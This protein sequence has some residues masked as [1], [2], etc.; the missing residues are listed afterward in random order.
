MW[1]LFRRKVAPHPPKA[2]QGSREPLSRMR[3]FRLWLDRIAENTAL[4]TF[5]HA[6]MVLLIFTNI[7]LLIRW[8]ERRY[9]KPP[10]GILRGELLKN[11]DRYSPDDNYTETVLSQVFSPDGKPITMCTTPACGRLKKMLS[12][13]SGPKPTACDDFYKH[14]CRGHKH[15]YRRASQGLMVTVVTRILR[16]AK[17]RDEQQRSEESDHVRM[18]QHCVEGESD[19][20]DFAFGCD[21]SKINGTSSQACP[22]DYP[23]VPHVL[24]E[25][26][27]NKGSP[28]ATAEEFV[29]DFKRSVEDLRVSSKLEHKKDHTPKG[30]TADVKEAVSSVAAA[31]VSKIQGTSQT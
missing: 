31:V 11:Y 4:A 8:W 22:T 9:P 19:A 21:F 30:V 20:S 18:L 3:R 6:L 2:P 15:F 1:F 14:V 27:L 25:I 17:S 5:L 13:A 7:G 23:H 26:A 24:S 10:L 12:E 29:E 28:D 16:N